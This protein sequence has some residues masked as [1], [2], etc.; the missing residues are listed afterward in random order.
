MIDTMYKTPFDRYIQ[1]LVTI[2]TTVTFTDNTSVWPDLLHKLSSTIHG[3]VDEAY[4]WEVR[5]LLLE[6]WAK[7]DILQKNQ[8][9]RRDW[10]TVRWDEL[11]KLLSLKLPEEWYQ[12][13]VTQL[14]LAPPSD[15]AQVNFIDTVTY[16]R[17]LFEAVLE[18]LVKDPATQRTTLYF[19]AFL[20]QRHYSRIFPLLDRFLAAC[21]YQKEVA[22]TLLLSLDLQSSQEVVNL[23]E[24]SCKVL[25]SKQ[26]LTP[27]LVSFIEQY[28]NDFDPDYLDNRPTQELLLQLLKISD[29]RSDLRR[30]V[31]GWYR[32]AEC[33]QNPDVTN[34]RLRDLGSGM[35]GITQLTSNARSKLVAKLVPRLVESA[36]T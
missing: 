23:L 1:L 27:T 29:L 22:E 20:A 25:L 16:Y 9:I 33:I 4:S 30:A 17:Q 6:T 32:I 2:L 3:R 24:N 5:S 28:L 8:Y 19:F 18:Q 12:V 13:S 31:E 10:L 26:D 15:F 11:D 21:Q 14:V 34:N 36:S 7:I 35:S